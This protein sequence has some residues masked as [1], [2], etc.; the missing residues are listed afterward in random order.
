M[1]RVQ[2]QR[3]K[4]R[5]RCQWGAHNRQ[6]PPRAAAPAA[7]ALAA[8]TAH[9]LGASPL[10]GTCTAG[11]RAYRPAGLVKRDSP[12]QNVAE[13]SGNAQAQ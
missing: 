9:R 1:R 8:R 3:S 2:Q 7:T 6:H 10:H 13:R 12:A 5:H 4:E 11:R